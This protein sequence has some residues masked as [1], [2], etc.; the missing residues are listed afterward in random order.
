MSGSVLP[1]PAPDP[2]AGTPP[3]SPTPDGA[4][5][6]PPEPRGDRRSLRLAV[7]LLIAGELVYAVATV[8]H[9]DA[10]DPVTAF[11]LYAGDPSWA[12][13]H[14]MQFLAAVIGTFALL[15][16]LHGLAVT[17]GVRGL[18]SRFAAA[19]AVAGLALNG[20]LYAVDG[21]ALKEVLDSWVSAPAAAAPGWFTVVAGV[22]GI[23]WGL[24]G[25]VDFS[26]G[27]TL[28]LIAIVIVST[29]R[30]SR[31]VGYLMGV[32]GLAYIAQGVGY[33][34]SYT[35]VSDRFVL[36]STSY[37]VLTLV[38]TIWL[39]VIVWRMKASDGSPTYPR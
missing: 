16:L 32:T 3:G 7:A 31:V 25:Y 29:G 10:A 13:V 27:L 37:E 17:T 4:S 39:L 26:T 28:I 36:A 22:R 8:L 23:E 35:A 14:A 15:A 33:G 6:P 24:R 1:P 11:L 18:V 12:L 19:A 30:V 34:S 38:W 20:V 2:G 9:P 5:S 21:V